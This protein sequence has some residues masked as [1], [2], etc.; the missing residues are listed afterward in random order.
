[1]PG[2]CRSHP[3]ALREERRGVS[4]W[5]PVSPLRATFAAVFTLVAGFAL[6]AAF[7]HGLHRFDGQERKPCYPN[8]SCNQGLEC[9]SGV[10]VKEPG[11]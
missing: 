6:G 8:A 1:M 10:C 2:H 4:D 9:R 11:Q 5:E 7:I 3:W